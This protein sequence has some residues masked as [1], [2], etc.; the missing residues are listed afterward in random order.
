M[1]LKSVRKALV[2]L[3]GVAVAF[4]LLDEGTAQDVVAVLTAVLVYVVP[5]G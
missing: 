3:A 5:N 4:G 1:K 2:A